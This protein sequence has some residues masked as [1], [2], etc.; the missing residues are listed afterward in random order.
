MNRLETGPAMT[1]HALF[2][3]PGDGKGIDIRAIATSEIKFSVPI[4]AAYTEL[5]VRRLHSLCG[6]DKA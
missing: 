4:D 2:L 5:A 1:T 6:L 3:L